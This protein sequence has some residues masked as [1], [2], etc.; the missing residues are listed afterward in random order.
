MK[1]DFSRLDAYNFEHLVQALTRNIIGYGALSFGAGPDGGREAS[2]RGKAPFPSVAEQW[3]GYWVVQAK[4]RY[5]VT[6]E[7]EKDFEW[8]RHKLA[9]ELDRYVSGV[10]KTERPDNYLLFTNITL[11]A[12]AGNGGRDRASRL[13]D[14]YAQKYGIQNIRIIGADDIRELLDNNRDVAIA[15]APFV[16]PGDVLMGLLDLLEVKGRRRARIAELVNRFLEVEFL[17]N[18]QAKLDHAGKLTS[19]R[20]NLEKVFIDMFATE[21][22]KKN[23]EGKP[24]FISA[25][26]AEGN[27]PHQSGREWAGRYVVVAGPGYGKSTLTQFLAQVYRAFFLKNA[28]S[29]PVAAEVDAFLSSIDPAIPER[30]KWV[31]LPFRI[32]IKEYAAWMVE[33]GTQPGNSS[34]ISYCRSLINRLSLS[35]DIS[36]EEVESLIQN[37]PCLFVF[38]GLD[39]VPSSS[40]RK[41]VLKEI[42]RFTDVFLRRSGNHHLVIATTRPQ[43][44]TKEFDSTRYQHLYIQ[45]LSERDCRAYIEKLMVNLIEDSMERPAKLQILYNALKNPDMVRL[46]QSPLQVAIMAILVRSG[47]ELA[48]NRYDL[49]T[50]YYDI[51]YRREKQKGIYPILAENP[52]Y[53]R[54]IHYELGLHLQTVSEKSS[55]AAALISI[56]EF[57]R[58]IKNYLRRLELE[59]SDIQRVYNEILEAATQRLVFITENEDSKIG[60][61][62][63]SLQE[64][65][66]AN[67]YMHNV[68]DEQIVDRI[69]NISESAYWGNVLLFSI[70]YISKFKSYLVGSIESLCYELN[71]SS[72]EQDHQRAGAIVRLGSWL[73]LDILVEGIF[74]GNPGVENKFFQLLKALFDLP[75][76]EAHESLRNLPDRLKQRLLYTVLEKEVEKDPG[77]ETAWRVFAHLCK[78]EVEIDRLL[79]RF[80][81]EDAGLRCRI[82]SVVIRMEIIEETIVP[83]LLHFIVNGQKA[84]LLQLFLY[85]FSL[86]VE[87]AIRYGSRPVARPILL[88]MLFLIALRPD[89]QHIQLRQAFAK[90]RVGCSRDVELIRAIYRGRPIAFGGGYAMVIR[91]LSPL[92]GAVFANL[93]T[94][95]RREGI[96]LVNSI[97]A[98]MKKPDLDGYLRWRTCME[99]QEQEFRS[100]V[101]SILKGFSSFFSY[102]L[103]TQ[104]TPTNEQLLKAMAD[105]RLTSE[106]TE[107]LSFQEK[108]AFANYGRSRMY[109]VDSV[110]V[111][112]QF[113]TAYQ[114]A[115]ESCDDLLDE[116]FVMLGF[117]YVRAESF[118]AEAVRSNP[119]VRE[120]LVRAC[121]RAIEKQRQLSEPMLNCLL[122]TLDTETLVDIYSRG[123]LYQR[124]HFRKGDS[125]VGDR[126]IVESCF[127]NAI[128]LVRA[129]IRYKMD[130]AYKT[131]F[132]A[133]TRLAYYMHGLRPGSVPYREMLEY[134]SACGEEWYKIGLLLM[135]ERFGEVHYREMQRVILLDKPAGLMKDIAACVLVAAEHSVQNE[136]VEKT[137]VLLYPHLYKNYGETDAKIVEFLRIYSGKK[138][139]R[140]MPSMLNNIY[141]HPVAPDPSAVHPSPAV[142]SRSSDT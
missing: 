70:G 15:Y 137:I 50:D 48:H 119:R 114:K 106:V 108:L 122:F 79:K 93:L 55:N 102:V 12:S 33:A 107:K 130:P 110:L 37:L 139:A 10:D 83:Y 66:A 71:G 76:V 101:A 30:P 13:E 138:T 9:V 54:H 115:A 94:A 11:T 4:F 88:E 92:P 91:K 74:R 23:L 41:E 100:G 8:I 3:D 63:R 56:D 52:D 62:I 7:D 38:D 77:N 136:F 16:L 142:N 126:S 24:R 118:T 132:Q 125:P 98:F 135:D 73:A 112:D 61:A 67:G 85:N 26:M 19:D 129:Q 43:G 84:Q 86:F 5:I 131:L 75:Y 40:N 59:A 57:G 49:F 64:Y 21:E 90:M 117:C 103:A 51:I 127:E 42:Y 82:L 120:M 25:I 31:R 123:P 104:A 44:Y 134:R 17:E 39:E 53:V 95:A 65:F 18:L 133:T 14:E 34:V 99:V 2:F 46:M 124:Y 58:L 68:R 32:T 1:Y 47:G 35:G 87:C 6:T 60:F 105:L 111:L 96:E 109:G 29:Y 45:D 69:A 141:P 121:G 28:D 20:I 89:Y 128:D 113:L 22:G 78:H 27:Q 140:S 36:L 72:D 97:A 116:F 80:L 81:P